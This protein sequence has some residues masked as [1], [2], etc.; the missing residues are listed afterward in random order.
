MSL[1]NLSLHEAADKLAAG[2]VTSRQLCEALF[3]Q[4]GQSRSEGWCFGI[5]QP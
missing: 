3:A 4:I 1:I 2:E 5:N